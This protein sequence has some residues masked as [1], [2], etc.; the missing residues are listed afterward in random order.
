VNMCIIGDNRRF[1][2]KLFERDV[3]ILVFGLVLCH[4]TAPRA[5]QP[6]GLESDL[7]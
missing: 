5:I 3:P 2:V 7:R 6:W 1:E 4:K